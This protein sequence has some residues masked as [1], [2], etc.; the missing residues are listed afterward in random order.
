MKEFP[1]DTLNRLKKQQGRIPLRHHARKVDRWRRLSTNL[2]LAFGLIVAFFIGLSF[3]SLVRVP[4]RSFFHRTLGPYAR[5]VGVKVP[6]DA[7]SYYRR[8]KSA[9]MNE[10]RLREI[11]HTA[12]NKFDVPAELVWAV[13][14]VE[15][16]FNPAARSPAGA[17]GLMQLMPG[18]ARDLKVHDPYDPYQN[19]LGGTKYLGYLLE[20]YNGNQ[21]MAVAAY[22]AGPANVKRHGGIPPFRETRNYVKRVMKLYQKNVGN[23]AGG[24]VTGPTVLGVW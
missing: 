1:A 8:P 3:F 17:M 2:G 23:V 10:Q 13:I 14:A 6:T 20:K 21:K 7:L 9:R 19:V 16:S 5:Q 4:G 11:V 24:V 18:T 22:N 15:S 12:S